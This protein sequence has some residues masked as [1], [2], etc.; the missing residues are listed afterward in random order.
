MTE[1]DQS[2]RGILASLLGLF[3]EEEEGALEGKP[4]TGFAEPGQARSE[5]TPPAPPEPEAPPASRDE[6]PTE[7]GWYAV[8]ASQWPRAEH[9]A[10]HD[11]EAGYEPAYEPPPPPPEPVRPFVSGDHYIKGSAPVAERHFTESAPAPAPEIATEETPPI[12]PVAVPQPVE[13]APAAPEEVPAPEVERPVA[14][15][16]PEV[17]AAEVETPVAEPEVEAPAEPAREPAPAEPQ[18]EDAA[19]PTFEDMAG[20]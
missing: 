8:S 15:A 4:D 6:A 14:P 20:P 17:E 11:V 1:K 13:P 2:K 5:W 12:E 7:P 3:G 9:E 10:E 16:A 18:F 19:E